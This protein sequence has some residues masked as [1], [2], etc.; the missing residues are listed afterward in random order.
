MNK[1]RP[2]NHEFKDLKNAFLGIIESIKTTDALPKDTA[3][4][5]TKV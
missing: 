3:F 2:T 1:E 4:A 5:L